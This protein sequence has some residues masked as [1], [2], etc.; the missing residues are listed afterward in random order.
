MISLRAVAFINSWCH[1]INTRFTCCLRL[2]NFILTISSFNMA[3]CF[4]HSIIYIRISRFNFFCCNVLR[5]SNGCFTF[6]RFRSYGLFRIIFRCCRWLNCFN[7]SNFCILAA[8]TSAFE[9]A[10]SIAASAV[11]FLFE[12]V[13]SQ[14]FFFCCCTVIS[15]NCC[16]LCL[17]FICNCLF[18]C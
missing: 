10:P 9:C 4:C 2:I 5:L 13:V 1:L 14:H 12:L 18:R 7:F 3:I 11:V 6:I 8:S 16:F 15:I 17:Y